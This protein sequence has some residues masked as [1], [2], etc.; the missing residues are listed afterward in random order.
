MILSDHDILKA[1]GTGEIVIDPFRRESLGSNSYDVH[2]GNTL[3]IYQAADDTHVQQPLD[4]AKE[5]GFYY[6]TIPT[7]GYVFRPGTLYLGVTEEYTETHRHVPFLDGKCF[8]KGTRI[9]MADGALKTVESVVIGDNVLG[10]DGA[11]KRIVGT[12]SGLAPLYRVH[13]SR[14]ESYVVNGE[15]VL[16]LRCGR[17][18]DNKAYPTGA[19]V[20]VSVGEFLG[21]P[22]NVRKHLYGFRRPAKF[23]ASPSLPVDPYILGLWLG[24]GTT[25][26]A[27]LT[28]NN[29]DHE[30][31]A[32]L[33][34]HFPLAAFHQYKPGAQTVVL[35]TH[36]KTA[37]KRPNDFLEGLRLLHVADDKHIPAHVL[38]ASTEDRLALLAGL[39]DTDGSVNHCSWEITTA[40]PA[41][42]DGILQLARSLGFTTSLAIKVVEDTEYYRIGISGAVQDI[43]TKLSRK[44]EK[45]TPS[46]FV[47]RAD[48]ALTVVPEGTGAYYGFT[49]DAEVSDDRLFFLEDFTVAHN[50]SIG[51]LGVFIH[52]TAGRGDVGFCNHWTLELSVV[53]PVRIYAGMPIGQLIYFET[54]APDVPYNRKPQAKY[55]GRN[56]MPMP[57]QMWRNFAKEC[58]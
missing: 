11:P 20:R 15:Y 29:E 30:V 17:G 41:L 37:F 5:N 32:Y 21:L 49:L 34:E 24:D 14:G 12:H 33:K 56:P 7:G 28:I 42:R 58:P 39:L 53:Q 40:Y 27:Q 31:L 52:A 54:S 46:S 6:A 44:R 57:S 4:C 36:E 48:S 10:V 26:Q 35:T 47:G 19:V 45:L 25:G 55:Q 38:V 1:I 51:R 18:T 43:P 23:G 13:Q 8:G 22:A 50:S 2:L 9:W 3:V 16:V